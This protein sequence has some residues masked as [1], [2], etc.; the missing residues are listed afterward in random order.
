MF[1]SDSFLIQKRFAH[2]FYRPEIP[3]PTPTSNSGCHMREKNEQEKLIK[4]LGR[5]TCTTTLSAGGHFSTSPRV[6][7]LYFQ[8]VHQPRSHA[9]PN[10]TV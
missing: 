10:T 4:L 2:S 3:L 6:A 7:M 9:R 5:R 8:S 1:N